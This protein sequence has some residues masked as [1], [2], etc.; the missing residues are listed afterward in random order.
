MEPGCEAGVLRGRP[1]GHWDADGVQSVSA[2][3]A[4]CH[5]K[6]PGELLMELVMI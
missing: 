2:I 5:G 4:A 3:L 1:V 6:Q